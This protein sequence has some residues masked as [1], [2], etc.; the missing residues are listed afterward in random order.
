MIGNLFTKVLGSRN[1]RSLRRMAK[2]VSA[3]NKLE[4]EL[5]GLTDGELKGK[6]DLFRTRLAAGETT[7]DLLPEAFAVVREV[8]VRALGMRHFDVQL[9]GGM[10]L[11]DG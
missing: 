10:A 5:Q 1:D 2:T 3:I 8:A 6:T 4:P 11:N 7:A 9:M